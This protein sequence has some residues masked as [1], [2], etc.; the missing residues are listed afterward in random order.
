[1]DNN[2]LDKLREIGYSVRKCCK[3]CKHANIFDF[4]WG[5]CTLHSYVH[6]K[7]TGGGKGSLREL[8]ITAQGVCDD[9][10]TEQIYLDITNHYKEFHE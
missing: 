7:H 1:M 4:G 6:K 8:S 5:T 9:H 10:E 3:T 2:K